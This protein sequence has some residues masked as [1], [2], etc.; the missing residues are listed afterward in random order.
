MGRPMNVRYSTERNH[1]FVVGL[2]DLQKL[3]ELLDQQVGSVSVSAKCGDEITREFSDWD[4]LSSYDNAPRREV[5]KLSMAAVSADV[6]VQIHFA[7]YSSANIAVSVSGP[8]RTT[9]RIREEVSDSLDATKPWYSAIVGVNFNQGFW[10]VYFLWSWWF[11]LFGSFD[12][13]K[14]KGTDRTIGFHLP[15]NSYRIWG[16]WGRSLPHKGAE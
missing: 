7:R 4:Q 9:M 10:V 16:S 5:I 6:S 14:L 15:F 11:I 1:A 3:W 8:E 2:S 13:S 12:L